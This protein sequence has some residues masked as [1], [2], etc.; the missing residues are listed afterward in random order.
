M[1]FGPYIFSLFYPPISSAKQIMSSVQSSNDEQIGFGGLCYAQSG[2]QAGFIPIV[3]VLYDFSKI[4]L[5]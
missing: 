3:I 1:T 2:F 5:K 4:I